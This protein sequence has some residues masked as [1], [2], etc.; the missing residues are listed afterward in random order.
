MC[1]MPLNCQ[2]PRTPRVN[3]C[4]PFSPGSSHTKLVTNT[5]GKF[6]DDRPRLFRMLKGSATL[7]VKASVPIEAESRFFE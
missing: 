2:P 5:C 6:I 4:D 3:G 7:P 1:Q